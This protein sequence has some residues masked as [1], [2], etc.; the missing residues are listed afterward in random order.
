MIKN[1]TTK[2]LSTYA[3]NQIAYACHKLAKNLVDHAAFLDKKGDVL[4]AKAML[5]CSKEIEA[6]ADKI[7]L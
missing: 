7:G 3:R 2:G 6:F 5:D 1:F 4:E